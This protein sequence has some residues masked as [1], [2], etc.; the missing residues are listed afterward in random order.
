MKRV[1]YLYDRIMTAENVRAAWESYNSH[2]PVC[3]RVEFDQARADDIL[4]RMQT[5]FAAV[6]GKPRVKFIRESGKLRRLQIPSFESC[7]A[8]LAL[9]NVCGPIIER[10]IHDNSFSSRK[11]KG[12][13]ALVR[14]VQRFVHTHGRDEARYCLY[15][16]ISKYY[17]HI[18]RRI[19]V[20]RLRAIIKDE[21]VIELFAK[22]LASTDQGLSIGYPFSHALANLYL[23]PLY[24][25]VCS[26]RNISRVWVYMD[27]WLI[28]SRF[29]APLKRALKSARAYL[30]GLGCSIKPDW[31]IFPTAAR[32]VK[33][34]GVAIKYG[35]PDRLYKRLWRRTVR[36]FARLVR[37]LGL[38]E[39]LGMRSRLGWLDLINRRHSPI[40]N[41]KGDY[42]W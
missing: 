23:T 35:A 18:D 36:N 21:R 4:A 33:V 10:R 1:G 32:A 12:G 24:Y 17:A 40:F 39:L 5:D 38:D 16:D 7:V 14:K 28:F 6:I 15:F 9:W 22:V 34:C 19:V 26:I 2:R 11:G 29:K 41:Y 37:G 20:D 25:L 3:R 8:Q 27:N 30:R 42:L 31:Q 13:H